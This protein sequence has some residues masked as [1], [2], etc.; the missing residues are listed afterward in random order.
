MKRVR[1]L[2]AAEDRA[3]RGYRRMR[4]LLDLQL[5]RDLSH[6]TGLSEPDY[7]VLSTLTEAPEPRWRASDLAAHLRWSSSRLAHHVGRMERRGLVAREA[8]DDDRR[9]AMIVLTETGWQTLR[10]AAPLHVE[11]VRRHFIDLLTPAELATLAAISAK[12][13]DHLAGEQAPAS[14]SQR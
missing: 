7:D 12:V 9:G 1:W 6:D 2:T 13:V 4:T 5:A 10:A 8:C 3:W 14:D 11:S